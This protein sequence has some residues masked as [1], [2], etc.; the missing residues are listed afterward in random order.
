MLTEWV[1]DLEQELDARCRLVSEDDVRWQP[2][3]DSNSAGVTVWHVARWCD[4]L[5]SR[6]YAGGAAEQDAWH[7][8]GWKDST[9][10]EPDGVGF[11]GLGTLTGY[12]PAEMRAVPHLG[13]PALGEYLAQCTQRLVAQID[14]LGDGVLDGPR[15]GGLTPYQTIGATLQGSFGHVGEIDALVALRARSAAAGQ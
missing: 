12:T 15:I 14:A 2:H 7:Q 11:L 6:W 8:E 5:G 13:A 4:V 3:P 9:G 1:R 10:Y